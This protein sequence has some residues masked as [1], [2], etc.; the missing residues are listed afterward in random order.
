MKSPKIFH[1][2][3][4]AGTFDTSELI[5]LDKRTMHAV[6]ATV[7]GNSPY[8]SLIAYAFDPQEQGLIFLTPRKTTKY[9]NMKK[10]QKVSLLIDT[11][12]NNETDYSKA[13]AFTITGKAILA[14]SIREKARLLKVFLKKHPKLASF[15]RE[16]GT[17]LIFIKITACMRA[18]RFQE[19]SYWKP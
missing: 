7:T 12:K 11:R 15:A 9:D 13:E 17:A 19:I 14:G 2:K 10:N 8:T 1:S 3:R 5:K 6:L 16:K 4:Y 18:G